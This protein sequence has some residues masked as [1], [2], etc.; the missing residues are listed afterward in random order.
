MPFVPAPVRRLPVLLLPL[1]V[2]LAVLAGPG[3]PPAD[4]ASVRT[5]AGTGVDW[6]ALAR[7]ESGGRWSANTGNGYYGGL[8]FDAATWRANGGPAYAPRAD[9]ATREQQIAVAERLA[10]RRGLAPWAACGARIARGGEPPAA[11]AE[12]RERG[13]RPARTRPQTPA[14]PASPR[15]GAAGHQ[16]EAVA[17]GSWTVRDGDTL[18]D[19][20]EASGIAGGWPALYELNR[21]AVGEDPDLLLPGQVLVLEP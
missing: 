9:R 21:D 2:L 18:S 1:L 6:D 20:A 8:Q 17:E 12:T 4:A 10:G 13:D 14:V 7:C 3:T 5:G 11:R 19:I 16:V 15:T